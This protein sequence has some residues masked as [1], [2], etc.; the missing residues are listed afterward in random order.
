[1]GIVEIKVPQ[2]SY[3]GCTILGGEPDYLALHPNYA[4]YKWKYSAE[5]L[6]DE[7]AGI[8]KEYSFNGVA[9]IPKSHICYTEVG[10][11]HEKNVYQILIKSTG[12]E[13][14]FEFDNMKQ[15]RATHKQICDW[16]YSKDA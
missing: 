3:N 10:Y 12:G 14:I 1:M 13:L 9:T 7:A 11:T 15:A 8:K 5:I 6:I 2:I 16:L 4:E